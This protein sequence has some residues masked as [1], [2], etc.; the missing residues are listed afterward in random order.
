MKKL[1]VLCMLSIPVLSMAQD[2]SES[3]SRMA[4]NAFT[5]NTVKVDVKLA[6]PVYM[7]DLMCRPVRGEDMVVR[8]DYKQTTCTGILS[9]QKTQ[10]YV[11]LSCVADGKYKASQINLTFADGSRVSKNHKSIKYQGKRAFIRL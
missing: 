4:A 3:V 9:A 1:V 8:V 11:P 7:S 2:L 6:K 10:V 5:R